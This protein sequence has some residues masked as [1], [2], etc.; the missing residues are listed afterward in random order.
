MMAVITYIGIL[1]GLSAI[2]LT[3]YFSFRAIK[4]I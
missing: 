3:L 2:A 1:I 4:L